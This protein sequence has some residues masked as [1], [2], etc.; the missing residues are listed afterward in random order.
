MSEFVVSA[1]MKRRAEPL[2]KVQAADATLRRVLDDIEH[3][4]GTIRTFNPEYRARKVK[5]VPLPH[6]I[7]GALAACEMP[8]RP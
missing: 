4:D 1:L 7:P 2:K 3:D 5:S 8:R 6:T